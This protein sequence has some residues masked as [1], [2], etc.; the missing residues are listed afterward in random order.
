GC[1]RLRERFPAL[2][3]RCRCP[4]PPEEGYATPALFALREPPRFQRRPLPWPESG[5]V[6]LEGA[7]A[8][9]EHRLARIEAALEKIAG[10]DDAEK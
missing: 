3:S 4:E 2:A 9:L 6:S 1:K 8:D 10:R 7:P 5:D